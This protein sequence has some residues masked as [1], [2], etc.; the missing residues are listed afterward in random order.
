[1]PAATISFGEDIHE[2]RS[3]TEDEPETSPCMRAARRWTDPISPLYTAAREPPE[4]EAS[5]ARAPPNCLSNFLSA[6][7]FCRSRLNSA[8]GELF[9]TLSRFLA[10]GLLR[11]LESFRPSASRR[12][13]R[14]VRSF[15]DGLSSWVGANFLSV[16]AV[17]GEDADEERADVDGTCRADSCGACRFTGL[18]DAETDER[19]VPIP[20]L[21]SSNERIFVCLPNGMR[22]F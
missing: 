11:C 20:R 21:A 6:R 12:F 22:P 8:R 16:R 15:R 2:A 13:C 5:A 14:A 18:P 19:C 17:R 7:F 4:D 9:S 1:M 10:G 3:D